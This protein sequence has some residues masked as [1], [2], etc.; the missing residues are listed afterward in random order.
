MMLNSR[1]SRTDLRGPEEGGE[2]GKIYDQKTTGVQCKT[3]IKRGTAVVFRS[4]VTQWCQLDQGEGGEKTAVR[5][6]FQMKAGCCFFTGKVT[7]QV[8]QKEA[9]SKEKGG[10]K[11]P[12]RVQ[13]V[14]NY[15]A[16]QSTPSGRSGNK[17]TTVIDPTQDSMIVPR[18]AHKTESTRRLGSLCPRMIRTGLGN[19]P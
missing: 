17:K 11:K 1:T 10:E 3:W 9:G 12:P 14:G 2:R 19:A 15:A 7:E 13:P 16:G 8:K 4:I 18:G 5:F 6:L